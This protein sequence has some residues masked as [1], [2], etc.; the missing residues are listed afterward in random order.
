MRVGCLCWLWWWWWGWG[1]V[2]GEPQGFWILS[3]QRPPVGGIFWPMALPALLRWG[4]FFLSH[5]SLLFSLNTVGWKFMSLLMLGSSQRNRRRQIKL[6]EKK[7]PSHW[8]IDQWEGIFEH[9][10]KLERE[11]KIIFWVKEKNFFYGREPNVVIISKKNYFI[12]SSF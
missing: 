1:R 2:V 3:Q 6:K 10:N 8:F 7:I 5:L 9:P 12:S 4:M 11:K